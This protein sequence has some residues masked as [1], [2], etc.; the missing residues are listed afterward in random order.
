MPNGPR[1]SLGSWAGADSEVSQGTRVVALE[2]AF[3]QPV[4]VRRTSKQLGLSTEA[5]YRFERGADISQPVVALERVR[6]LL[7]R[8]GTGRARGPVI[9]RYPTPRVPGRI[10]FRHSRIRRLLGQSI[11]PGVRRA[12]V[13][14]P[15]LHAGGVARRGSAGWR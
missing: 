6:A 9:D 4:S 7:E 1:P 13:G 3:F 2:S 11:D 14:A 15:R 8:I 10:T 5:S 12:D